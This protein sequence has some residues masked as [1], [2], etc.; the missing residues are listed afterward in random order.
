MIFDFITVAVISVIL[1]FMTAHKKDFFS[2]MIQNSVTAGFLL[3]IIKLLVFITQLEHFSKIGYLFSSGNLSQNP[4]FQNANLNLPVLVI[5]KFRPLITGFFYRIIFSIINTINTAR[6][7]K[8]EKKHRKTTPN[9]FTQD[10][11]AQTASTINSEQVTYIKKQIDYSPLS[12]REIEVARLAAKGY[13]NAQIADELFISTETV[14]SHMNSIFEKLNISS[15]K[16]LM[17]I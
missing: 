15:R 9:D 10:N 6:K 16:E 13:T 7:S 12:R 8:K 11:S 4:D 1:T 14:K 17:L 5:V 3:T 2:K